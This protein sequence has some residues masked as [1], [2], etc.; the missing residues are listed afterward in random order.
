[1]LPSL[2]TNPQLQYEQK[3]K[4]KNETLNINEDFL[5]FLNFSAKQQTALTSS[6]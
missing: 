1:M 2:M 3:L 4:K 6:Y 5:Q